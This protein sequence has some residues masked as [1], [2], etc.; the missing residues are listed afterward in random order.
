MILHR[1]AHTHSHIHPSVTCCPSD[2]F[3]CSNGSEEA[4][5]SGCIHSSVNLIVCCK[6]IYACRARAIKDFSPEGSSW[7]KKLCDLWHLPKNTFISLSLR[8]FL[9]SACFERDECKWTRV[10]AFRARSQKE[11]IHLLFLQ[12]V[13]MLLHAKFVLKGLDF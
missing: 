10:K 7:L 4:E 13:K 12:E 3:A 6:V 9:C 8:F 11:R 5:K 2:T 1:N